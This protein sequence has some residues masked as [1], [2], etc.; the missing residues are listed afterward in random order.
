MA[1]T[2]DDAGFVRAPAWLVYRRLTRVAAWPDW[3]TGCRVRPIVATDG[4]ERWAVQLAVGPLRRLRV[5]VRP[6]GWRQELG[7]ELD[8]VGDVLGGSEFWLEA[9][10]G[11][12]VVH[13]VANVASPR[14][15]P[16]RVE[17][18]YRRAVRRGLW[19]LKEALQLEAR[20]SAGLVP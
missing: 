10:H 18:G 3:W 1:A 4:G 11:G 7:V 16:V 15:R 2:I 14:A 5:E 9:T 12:V 8:L 6:H 19:G 13:H 17:T 20:T